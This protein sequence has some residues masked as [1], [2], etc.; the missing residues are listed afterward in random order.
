MTEKQQASASEEFGYYASKISELLT[1]TITVLNL[2][3]ST[4]SFIP[5]LYMLT[6]NPESFLKGLGSSV[7]SN[8][9]YIFLYEKGNCENFVYVTMPLADF[10]KSIRLC[11]NNGEF[12][13]WGLKD[14]LRNLKRDFVA[15]TKGDSYIMF[16]ELFHYSNSV[17]FSGENPVLVV[18]EVT[19]KPFYLISRNALEEG[20]KPKVF[21]DF[22][23]DALIASS[24][25]EPKAEI[26]KNDEPVRIV[27]YLKGRSDEVVAELERYEGLGFTVTH[28]SLLPDYMN[29]KKAILENYNNSNRILSAIIDKRF[30]SDASGLLDLIM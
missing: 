2:E 17:I 9:V 29:T 5:A 12:I 23:S 15:K 4:L 28:A 1:E 3:D 8:S 6:D 27:F 16:Q 25:P 7:S 30:S 11:I 13:S 14:V 19:E 24:Y 21:F 18:P 10:D 20:A 26:C 22:A